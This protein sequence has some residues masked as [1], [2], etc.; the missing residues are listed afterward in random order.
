MS[1]QKTGPTDASVDEFLAAAVPARRRED[2]V[3]LAALYREARAR[4][5]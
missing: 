1:A 3:A 2:G 5:R 4:S